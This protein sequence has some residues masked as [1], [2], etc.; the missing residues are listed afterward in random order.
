MGQFPLGLPLFPSA[1]RTAIGQ[2][3][4]IKMPL[5]KMPLAIAFGGV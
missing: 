5:L 4:P 2:A 1:V 3:W